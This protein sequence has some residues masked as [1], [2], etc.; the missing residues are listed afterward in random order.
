M[1]AELAVRIVSGTLR[2]PLGISSTPM[3]HRF[4][5]NDLIAQGLNQ[6]L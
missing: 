1:F 3:R 6:T 5:A 2:I 4:K